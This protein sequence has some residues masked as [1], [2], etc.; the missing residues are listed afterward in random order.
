MEAT[1]KMSFED[2]EEMLFM[3]QICLTYFSGRMGECSINKR[4][5]TFL[6]P[7]SHSNTLDYFRMMTI[8]TCKFKLEILCCMQTRP[9]PTHCIKVV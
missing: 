7:L 5:Y 4:K 9:S 2:S 1:D 8:D 3:S 6:K